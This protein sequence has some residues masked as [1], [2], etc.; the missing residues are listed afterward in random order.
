MQKHWGWLGGGVPNLFFLFQ[1]LMEILT[2]GSDTG[3]QA[4]SGTNKTL[5]SGMHISGNQV[6]FNCM[7]QTCNVLKVGT[8]RRLKQCIYFCIGRYCVELE[9]G[10]NK[11]ESYC[12]SL[13]ISPL[14]NYI[15]RFPSYTHEIIL[16]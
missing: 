4:H 8:F 15:V 14:Q 16:S 11:K 1:L 7:M 5:P 2:V 13:P 6:F 3:K 10:S 12:I 9:R